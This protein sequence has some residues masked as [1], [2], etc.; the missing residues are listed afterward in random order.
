[1]R[2]RPRIYTRSTPPCPSAPTRRPACTRSARCRA[3]PSRCWCPTERPRPSCA[4]CRDRWCGASRARRCARE[5]R[6]RDGERSIREY[7]GCMTFEAYMCWPPNYNSAP[8][9]CIVRAS[10]GAW[11]ALGESGR[12]PGDPT[13][14]KSVC[15]VSWFVDVHVNVVPCRCLSRET[16]VMHSSSICFCHGVEKVRNSS[17]ERWRERGGGEGLRA[18]SGLINS[19]RFQRPRVHSHVEPERSFK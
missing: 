15:F 1:M 2:R 14:A 17:M 10:H 19:S 18:A 5:Q 9:T 12:A 3:P 11:Q 13:A 8:E 7:G 4:P 16:G 6:Q